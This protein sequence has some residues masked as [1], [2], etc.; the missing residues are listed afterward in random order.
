[1]NLFQGHVWKEN[2]IEKKGEFTEIFT[3]FQ[4]EKNGWKVQFCW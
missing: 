4:Q 2:R 3:V 1:M